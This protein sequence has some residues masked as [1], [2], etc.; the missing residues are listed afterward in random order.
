MGRIVK[1]TESH[2]DVFSYSPQRPWTRKQTRLRHL[3]LPQGSVL[4][5]A[6][7]GEEQPN[8]SPRPDPSSSYKHSTD[9]F[10]LASDKPV[11]YP[12]Y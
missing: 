2:R 9:D 4:T 10:F 5:G 1:L 6:V 8:F 12:H 11:W 7:R 3:L